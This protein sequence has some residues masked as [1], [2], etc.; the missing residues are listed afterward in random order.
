MNLQRLSI[1]LSHVSLFLLLV[2][3]M[4]CRDMLC[5]HMG[6]KPCMRAG[7]GSASTL[8]TNT[9]SKPYPAL[10][11]PSS[12]WMSAVPSFHVFTTHTA[13]NP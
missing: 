7:A 3:L 13:V 4:L 10:N 8:E 11:C 2:Q 1:Q 9:N 12:P 6:F 5:S